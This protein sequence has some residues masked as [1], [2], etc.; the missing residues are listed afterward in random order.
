M[1]HIRFFPKADKEQ[2]SQDVRF[3]PKA[4]S[5]GAALLG[6]LG[7]ASEQGRELPVRQQ[8]GCAA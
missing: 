5:C 6:N 7:G 1:P 8:M 2:T 4:D 3:V